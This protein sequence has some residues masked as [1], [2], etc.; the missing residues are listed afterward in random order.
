M[1]KDIQASVGEGWQNLKIGVGHAGAM[2][3]AGLRELRAML[4]PESNISQQT[5]LGIYGTALPSE[6]ATVRQ[7]DG[8]ELN[9]INDINP[10]LADRI[11]ALE[12]QPATPSRE[13]FEL[14]KE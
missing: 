1:L 8:P 5:E 4:Y 10:G 12:R 3:R 14:E 11:R 2:W 6:V 7:R 9:T 13:D